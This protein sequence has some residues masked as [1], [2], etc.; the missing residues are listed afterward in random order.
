MLWLTKSLQSNHKG[1]CMVRQQWETFGTAAILTIVIG[2][3]A[4]AKAQSQTA[5]D[6]SSAEGGKALVTLTRSQQSYYLETSH[7]ARTVAALN[8]DVS[9][10][11][12]YLQRIKV[13]SRLSVLHYAIARQPDRKSFVG[14][15]IVRRDRNG[16]FRSY[17]IVCEN[18]RPGMRLPAT[19][20]IGT[21]LRPIC[22][23]GTTP[24]TLNSIATPAE[25]EADAK[26]T[27]GTLTRAQQSYF[28]ENNR[29]AT[30]LDALSLNLSPD[31]VGYSY[32]IAQSNQSAIQY[33]VSQ[34][35]NLRSYVGA[36][37]IVAIGGGEF[38]TA[39]IVCENIQ[40]GTLRP[41]PPTVSA[42]G[43]TL[44]CAAG[45]RSIGN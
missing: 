23:P 12:N 32:S 36:V 3:I 7:F 37:T 39:G 29:F 17:S 16:D 10:T 26:R 1:N 18:N 33:G 22:A 43:Q 41:A 42:N 5:V 27:V 45:T 11:P 30:S 15:V 28:L 24:W 25:L 9:T 20:R 19:P 6:L 2:A 38:N 4:P 13:Q 35:I 21:N 34:K 31:T 14:Q 8:T 40:P 44:V